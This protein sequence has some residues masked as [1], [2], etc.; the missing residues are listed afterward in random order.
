MTDR[1]LVI[2]LDGATWL[3]LDP[4]MRAGRMPA[5]AAL[6]ERG[7]RSSLESTV[8]PVTAPAWSS[9]ITGQN[10][11]R[12]GVYQFYEIDPW[13]ER[14]LGRG[15]DT[16]MA[17]PGVVVNGAAL[18]G[19]KL[20]EVAGD[21][22][23]RCATINL[24]MTYP[25][26]EINGL[27]VTDMLTPP[28]SRRFT[29]PPELADELDDYEIDLTP[30]EKDFSSTDDAFL[31]RAEA[32]LDKRGRAVVTLFA[33]ERWDLFVAVFTESDRIQH[34]YWQHLDPAA[35]APRDAA[36]AAVRERVLALY[37]R[38]DGY[39]ARL[40]EAAGDDYRIVLVSDHGFGNAAFR[41]VNMPA[42]AAAIGLGG[43]PSA[44]SRLAKYGITKKR[45]SKYLGALVPEARLRNA[46]RLAR[47]RAL[48]DVKGKLVK[49]HDYIGGVWI[50]RASRGGPVADEE[51]P[52]FRAKLVE[53]LLAVVNDQTGSPFVTRAVGREELYAGERLESAPDV[54]FFL[55]DRYGLDPSP[56]DAS[57]VYRWEP[58]TTG[59]HRSDGIF[60]IAGDGVVAR[61][62]TIPLG[63]EDCAPTILHLLGLPVPAAM[64]GRVVEEAL[65]PGLLAARPV[66]RSEAEFA[67]A[68]ERGAW[69]SDEEQDEI[70]ERLRGI[71]YVE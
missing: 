57:L 65:A 32:V 59:T 30:R 69:D 51:V 11:G 58:P 12:H 71:G 24:P 46:E 52:A 19:P 48:R 35:R 55:D 47:D 64:D 25:P 18:G 38:L 16:F 22:G 60:L 15:A 61:E 34:R 49:L 31:A 10:P 53:R 4:L 17:E 29:W 39:V 3:A 28:G 33:R 42:L 8:P 67:T 27:M 62:P 63:I 40:V 66:V 54:V 41:R 44:T 70:M 9:F 6:V 5:L 14:S 37:E 1:V 68:A 13:S 45:L 50:H 26:S 7:F 2:G 56:R 23:K 20:W 21:G 36:E 43:A